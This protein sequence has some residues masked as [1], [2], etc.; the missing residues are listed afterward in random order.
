LVTYNFTW[1]PTTDQQH[2]VSAISF[3]YSLLNTD[4]QQS[5]S[6]SFVCV[7][8][9]GASSVTNQFVYSKGGAY[10]EHFSI[11]LIPNQGPVAEATEILIW[12]HL[13]TAFTTSWFV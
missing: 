4:C 11:E 6:P 13:M 7:N 2:T 9:Y 8:E 1:A 10:K 3:F 12:Q 5:Y